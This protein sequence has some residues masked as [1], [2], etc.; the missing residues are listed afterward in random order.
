[1]LWEQR[2]VRDVAPE[3][4]RSYRSRREAAE[5]AVGR[6]SL[7]TPQEMQLLRVCETV[8]ERA[9]PANKSPGSPVPLRKVLVLVPVRVDHDHCRCMQAGTGETVDV[10]H[11][12]LEVPETAVVEESRTMAMALPGAMSRLLWRPCRLM[13]RDS[14]SH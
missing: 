14:Q 13:P 6:G 3:I 2:D 1:M 7:E 12:W 9:L 8:R 5:I 10:P 4:E 11:V